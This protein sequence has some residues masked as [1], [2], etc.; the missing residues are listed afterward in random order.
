MS[1]HESVS[2]YELV[3]PKKNYKTQSF[4]SNK[5]NEHYFAK[6]SGC[7]IFQLTQLQNDQF[8]YLVFQQIDIGAKLG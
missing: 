7:E 2:F 3:N 8:D 4:Q 1:V 5:R 6:L